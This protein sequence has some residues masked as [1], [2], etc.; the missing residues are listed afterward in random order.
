MFSFF[1][2]KEEQAIER[3]VKDLM[4]D[5]THYYKYTDEGKKLMAQREKDKRSADTDAFYEQYGSPRIVAGGIY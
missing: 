2:S 5:N 3:Q 1:K 4:L